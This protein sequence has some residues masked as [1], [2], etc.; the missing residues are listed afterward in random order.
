MATAPTN[1]LTEP[2]FENVNAAWVFGGSAVR[3][4]TQAYE[5]AWSGKVV[6]SSGTITQAIAGTLTS[7]RRYYFSCWAKWLTGVSNPENRL[8]LR[9]G[10]FTYVELGQIGKLCI[11]T[12]AG[13]LISSENVDETEW[14]HMVW[15][16]LG[17][18]TSGHSFVANVA[19]GAG[20]WAI[21]TCWFGT[22]PAPFYIRHPH[23]PGRGRV[24]VDEKLGSFHREFDVHRDRY[25][26]LRRN[27]D[28]DDL[29][30][31]D[32]ADYPIPVEEE[33]PEP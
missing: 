22:D 20:H 7:N 13:T 15:A 26:L 25:E 31:D 3:D 2:G 19:S 10:S 21:D 6:N 33:R 18:G 11:Y 27:D 23:P 14:T 17:D 12:A 1:L 16:F 29:G 30:R 32:Y 24:Y 8:R 4:N 9:V 28:R 5:G